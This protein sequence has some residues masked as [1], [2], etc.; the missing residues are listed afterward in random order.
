MLII[1]ASKSGKLGFSD[2][3]MNLFETFAFFRG[4][5][6][7]MHLDLE[8][9]LKRGER[10]PAS[11]SGSGIVYEVPDKAFGSEVVFKGIHYGVPHKL[12]GLK[13]AA[14]NFEKGDAEIE[15]RKGIYVFTGTVTSVT[16]NIPKESEMFAK[17]DKHGIPHGKIVLPEGL[18]M[19]LMSKDGSELPENLDELKM[20]EGGIMLPDSPD[21]R[22]FS[23]R[24]DEEAYIGLVSRAGDGNL[25]LGDWRLV[26]A[27]DR[28]C[29]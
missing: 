21:L 6:P 3:E 5:R 16:K 24:D 1:S 26:D 27:E 2:K 10:M 13:N 17:P 28:T 14:A 23:R 9:C 25:N 18:D 8:E 11:R 12:R 4:K 19:R 29:L 15:Y 22:R 7:A 20:P